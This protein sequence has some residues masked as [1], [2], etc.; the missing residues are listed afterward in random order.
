[1][2]FKSALVTQAS[3]STGGATFAHNQGG[4][5]M[6]ARSVPVNPSTAQ[7]I[8]IRNAMATITNRWSSTLTATQRAGWDTYSTNVPIVG[9]LG[10]AR[11][12]GGLAMYVRSNNSRIQAGLTIVDAPPTTFTLGTFTLPTVS[13]SAATQLLSVTFT[14]TD[15]WANAVGGAM[16]VYVSRPQSAGINFFKGPYRYAGKISGAVSPPTS[17]QT[18]AVPFPVAAGQKLFVQVT[19]SRADGRLAAPFRAG[20]VVGS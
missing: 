4:L 17:P 11:K 16:L 5:Y 1:M 7:Q 14:N 10:D 13:A 19:V 12:V 2:K 15:D 18:F 20:L 9:P 3:G 6:R 8:V